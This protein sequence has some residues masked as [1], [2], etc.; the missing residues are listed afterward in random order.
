[1]T[2][3]KYKQKRNF[4]KSGEPKFTTTSTTTCQNKKSI[5][6]IH[7]HEA[8]H[9]HW[10]LR[11]EINGVL[12]SWAVPKE[13]PTTKG[14]KRLAIEVEDHPLN[15]ATFEGTIPEGNYGAGKVEIWDNGNFELI[16][17]TAPLG[18]PQKSELGGKIEF[19]LQGK[20]MKGNFVLIKTK[21]AKNSWLFFKV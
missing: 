17:N 7:R 5:F 11:L 6:V 2:L 21:Y 8:S 19:K 12:K 13:P 18:V 3:T 4:K 14:V 16:E 9:L 10:D 15:Y 1:M 20:K